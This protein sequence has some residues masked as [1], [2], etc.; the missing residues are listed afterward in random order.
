MDTIER[1]LVFALLM[2]AE[3]FIYI[4]GLLLYGDIGGMIFAALG[5]VLV[6]HLVTKFRI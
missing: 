4:L 2:M 6:W 1:A 3:A 5:A